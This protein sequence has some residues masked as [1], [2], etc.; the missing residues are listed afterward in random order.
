LHAAVPFYRVHVFG[1]A[2]AME[3]RGDTDL[4]VYDMAGNVQQLSLDAINKERAILESFAD[5][6]AA[7]TKFVIPPKEIVNVVAV[8]EAVVASAKTGQAID[9]A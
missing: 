9:I 1:S 8:T 2:G 7:G 4:F 6:A 5:A 3:M